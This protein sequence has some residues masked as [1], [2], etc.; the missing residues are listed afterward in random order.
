MYHDFKVTLRW[1][2][3]SKEWRIYTDAGQYT[4]FKSID[5]IPKKLSSLLIAASEANLRM[6]GL[7]KNA[8]GE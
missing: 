1:Y 3:D 6:A 2:A 5:E 4:S 7:V 8:T